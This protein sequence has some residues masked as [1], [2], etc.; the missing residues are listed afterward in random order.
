MNYIPF[1]V[2]IGKADIYIYVSVTDDELKLLTELAKRIE[3]KH[4]EVVPFCSNSLFDVLYKKVVNSALA[5]VAGTDN[6]A[7]LQEL[8]IAPLGD[9]RN[10][11]REKY[12]IYADYPYLEHIE[13]R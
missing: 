7:V 4:E 12:E 13:N 10:F 5:D 3:I 11:I 8:G 6:Y 2:C 1:P 9:I